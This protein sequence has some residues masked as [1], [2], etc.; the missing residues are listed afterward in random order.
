MRILYLN[1]CGQMGGAE[2]SLVSL[3]ASIR[4]ARPDWELFLAVGEAG[5]LLEKAHR[6]GVT[7]FTVPF[8]AA[9]AKLGDAGQRRFAVAQAAVASIVSTAKYSLRLREL[10]RNTRPAV[11]HSNGF[12]MHILGSLVCP[13][14]SAL[15]W[16]MHDYASTR[17][18]MSQLLRPLRSRCDVMIANSRSVAADLTAVY[19]G[20][21]IE[22]IYNAID[23]ERFSPKGETCDLDRISGLGEPEAGTIRVGLV[24]T[25]AR[26]KGH[27]VFLRALAALPLGLAVRGYVIGGPIYRTGGSQ[28]SLAELRS[29]TQELGLHGRVGFTGFLTD[30]ATAMRSL[31]ILVHASTEPE[32]FGMVIVE[33]MACGK[34]VIASRAGG[35]SELFL[36]GENALGHCPGDFRELAQ[37]IERLAA[38]PELRRR[39]GERARAG[40]EKTFQHTRLAEQL[41]PLYR[42]VFDS[43]NRS[44]ETGASAEAELTNST[45]SVTRLP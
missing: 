33:A 39:L 29:K 34:A 30:S 40:I 38:D 8:P 10:V 9:L 42:R 14:K 24:A 16:H 26:W 15:I 45:S 27:E 19:R 11:I 35:A 25:F 41:L 5:P 13:R 37:Q 28:H 44:G 32:P 1:A 22:T 23:V 17:P 18:V 12:K 20:V 7:A 6:R 36:D 43:V 3:M 2:A 21:P 31:D 4:E